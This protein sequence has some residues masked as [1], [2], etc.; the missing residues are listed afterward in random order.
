[1]LNIVVSILT[2]STLVHAGMSQVFPV[3]R[4]TQGTVELIRPETPDYESSSQLKLRSFTYRGEG[5]NSFDPYPDMGYDVG[6]GEGAA[7]SNVFEL[8]D[9]MHERC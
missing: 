8:W 4:V 9:G 5:G 6:T 2:S 1:M 3:D 7:F